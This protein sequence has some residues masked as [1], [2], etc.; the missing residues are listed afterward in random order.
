[1]IW[2]L[3]ARCRPSIIWPFTAVCSIPFIDGGG[4][5]LYIA[6]DVTVAPI[7]LSLIL[8]QFGRGSTTLH[9]FYESFIRRA[10]ATDSKYI[11]LG[12]CCDRL[13]PAILGAKCGLF[14]QH[15]VPPQLLRAAG[16]FRIKP[17]VF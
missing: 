9:L 5:I 14:Q 1:M 17:D 2:K 15:H 3:V 12:V 8:P 16:F 11:V 13:A 4:A 7:L 6:D 10:A